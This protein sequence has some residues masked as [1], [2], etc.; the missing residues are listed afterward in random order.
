MQLVDELSMIYT[1]CLMCYATF[2][3]AKSQ[4]FRLTLG[5]GLLFLSV[6]ITVRHILLEK[7]MMNKF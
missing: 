3:L 2:S 4:F 5:F 1:V 6:S 7:D